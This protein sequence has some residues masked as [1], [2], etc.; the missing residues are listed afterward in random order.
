MPP[1]HDEDD[2]EEADEELPSRQDLRASLRGSTAGTR[3]SHRGN[4]LMSIVAKLKKVKPVY[5]VL[6][7][8]GAALGV[9]YLMEGERS[10]VM[11]LYRGVFGHGHGGS[12]SGGGGKGRHALPGGGGGGVAPALAPIGTVIAPQTP[13]YYPAYPA[14]F[15]T[16]WNGYP[17]DA[18]ARHMSHPWG[19]AHEMLRHFGHGSGR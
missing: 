9:D 7:L 6:G 10:I 2:V 13:A 3:Q 1:K 8:G 15:Y 5:W 4:P 12:G 16:S 14:S 17:F 18:H 19:H 11:S